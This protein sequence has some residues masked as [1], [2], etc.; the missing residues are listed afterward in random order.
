MRIGI[1]CN[2]QSRLSVAAN[3]PDDLEEEFDKPETVEAIAVVL[4][5]LGHDVTVLGDGRQLLR[6][7]LDDAPEFV[8]NFAEG[9]GVSR[10]R[11]ARVPAVL[12]MLGIPFSGSDPLTLATTLDKD[13]CKRVVE[14]AGVRTPRGML[15]AYEKGE[16][17]FRGSAAGTDFE[18]ASLP[19]PLIVKPAYE[20]SSKGIRS[21][22]LV[23]HADD[24]PDVL[25]ELLA[26]Y[27]QPILVEEFIAGDEVTVGVIGND[28]P[29]VLGAMRIL[30]ADTAE[31][32]RFVYSLEV[33]RDWQRRVRYESPAKLPR[34]VL[35]RVQ[36][37][38]LTAYRVLGCRDVSRLDFRIR[39]GEPYLLEVNPLPGLSPETGDI[40]LLAKGYGVSHR[41]LVELIFDAACTRQGLEPRVK[42]RHPLALGRV[43]RT[44]EC[45][46]REPAVRFTHPTSGRS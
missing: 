32:D 33:K 38:A 7:L 17:A 21:K 2:V 45:G 19:F 15:A 9:T 27:E 13:C 3:T 40:V 20:G 8:F 22:C 14:S 6:R 44:N 41:E 42:S 36:A 35:E 1:T 5:D 16:L 12:E 26:T 4:R 18:T 11:E 25:N 29:R 30:P 34:A 39:D 37:A 28:P 10:S 23:Q 43:K 46:Q 24:F 31:R